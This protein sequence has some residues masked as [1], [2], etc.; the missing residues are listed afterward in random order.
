VADLQQAPPDAAH[1][2]A[3]AVNAAYLPWCATAIRSCLDHTLGGGLVI[4]VLH[5]GS[6]TSAAGADALTAMVRE[7]GGD[8]E[9]HEIESACVDHLPAEGRFGR[10]VW[11][12]FLLPDLLGDVDRVLYLDA[13]TLVV[14]PIDELWDLDLYEAP[15]AA[16]S[17]VVDRGLWPHVRSL[18]IEDPKRFFN[19][20][21]LLMDLTRMRAE[22]SSSELLGVAANRGGELLWPDQDALNIVFAE[23][24]QRLH[25]RWNAMNSLWDWQDLADDVFGPEQRTE[26]TTDPRIV[27]FEGPTL[28]KPWHTLNHHPYRANYWSVLRS[29]PWGDRKPED[30]TFIT[31]TIGRL[32]QERQLDWFLRLEQWRERRRRGEST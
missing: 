13:D 12:R 25:P 21:V 15:I 31:R 8:L 20:G 28:C 14:A 17:N 16:V 19:S 30:N 9:L 7:R 6:V 3:F 4:H 10:I 32:P 23:R 27:H 29:T 26:A 11:L 22:G 18:G 2:L 1:H 5:D 24:W